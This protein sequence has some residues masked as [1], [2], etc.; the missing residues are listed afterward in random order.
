LTVQD[1]ARSRGWGMTRLRWAVQTDH[2]RS[3]ANMVRTPRSL[4]RIYVRLESRCLIRHRLSRTTRRRT[5]SGLKRRIPS[6]SRAIQRT[7]SP[8]DSSVTT[9]LAVPR[10]TFPFQFYL[11]ARWAD[12]PLGATPQAHVRS[13]RLASAD[14]PA[15]AT[16]A[17]VAVTPGVH[18]RRSPAGVI[19]SFRLDPQGLTWLTAKGAH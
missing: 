18:V 1:S 9:K 10:G 16:S 6:T 4:H 2:N 7:V 5:G 11:Y 13:T 8:R 14:R 19:R 3:A 17:S 15:A 12:W